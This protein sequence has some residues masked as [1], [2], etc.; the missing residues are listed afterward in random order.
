ME[1]LNRLRPFLPA[2]YL[3]FRYAIDGVA[4]TKNERAR[5]V[6]HLPWSL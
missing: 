3:Y 6:G 5:P 1:T 2:L 4:D